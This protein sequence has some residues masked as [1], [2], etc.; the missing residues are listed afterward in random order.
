VTVKP[1]RDRLP[2]QGGHDARELDAATFYGG[3]A[4]GDSDY[5]VLDAAQ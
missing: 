5:P 4:K 2:A 1:R 3:D